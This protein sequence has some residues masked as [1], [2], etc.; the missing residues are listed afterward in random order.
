M[1]HSREISEGAL[2]SLVCGGSV[3]AGFTGVSGGLAQEGAPG[4]WRWARPL[5]THLRRHLA[6][7]AESGPVLGTGHSDS[8][9]G[10]Q[11]LFRLGQ[12]F[13]NTCFLPIPTSPT[14]HI[15]S[16]TSP[17]PRRGAR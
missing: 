5:R 1:W 12:C 9:R 11:S 2:Q 10:Q 16:G 8:E 15:S 4:R 6:V 3:C 17:E 7:S 14:A 13:S